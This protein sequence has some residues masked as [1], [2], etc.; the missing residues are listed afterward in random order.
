MESAKKLIIDLNDRYPQC[1]KDQDLDISINK[2]EYTIK[3][4]IKKAQKI[5]DHIDSNTG[6]QEAL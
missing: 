6:R 2:L 3:T 4:T 1:R 5:E